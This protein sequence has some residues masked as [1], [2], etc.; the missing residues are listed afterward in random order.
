MLYTSVGYQ[1]TDSCNAKCKICC[2]SSP[3]Q[4]GRR[5]D[6]ELILNSIDSTK[7]IKSINTIG[8]TGGEPFLY[9]DDVLAISEA[10]SK[11]GHRISVTTNA[12][13]C[14]SYDITLKVLSQLKKNNLT[15][16]IISTDAFHEEYVPIKYIKTLVRACKNV[17]INPQ[18]QSISTRSNLAHTD[19]II[20]ELGSD[21][22]NLAVFYGSLLPVGMA[23]EAVAS[24]DLFTCK[25]SHIVCPFKNTLLITSDGRAM[26]CCSPS[27]FDIPFDFGNIHTDSIS[28]I[29]Q[30]IYKCKLMCT[31]KGEGFLNLLKIAK[32]ERG[33]LELDGY[34]NVCH[35][36]HD[37]LNN[38][39]QYKYLQKKAEILADI[40]DGLRSWTKS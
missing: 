26:P 30:R 5:L 11:I 7:D 39:E 24:E 36:C 37:L 34:V 19:R 18:I 9:I 33:Y 14:E 38:P 22:I 28:I 4:D 3:L 32:E 35:L 40:Q 17:G 13:W 25:L 21:K 29:L 27:S 20:S 10:S 15:Y 12:F 6:I 23:K 16:C 2:T 1:L 8:I 31:I